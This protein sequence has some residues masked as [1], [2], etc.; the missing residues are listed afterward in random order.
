MAGELEAGVRQQG[1]RDLG[2]GG[3]GGGER[4]RHTGHVDAGRG[5][6]SPLGVRGSPRALLL[7][8]NQGA[9]HTRPQ[10]SARFWVCERDL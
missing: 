1:K 5:P 6:A 7:S 2:E 3:G 10:G 4:S 8:R 9:L